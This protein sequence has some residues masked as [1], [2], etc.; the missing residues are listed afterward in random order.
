MAYTMTAAL[1]ASPFLVSIVGHYHLQVRN[2]AP[3]AWVYTP[4][5]FSRA[6]TFWRAFFAP[7]VAG[8]ISLIGWAR[9]FSMSGAGSGA[10]R[11]LTTSAVVC[12]L[13]LA[14]SYLVQAARAYG[15]W[16]PSIVPG[17][18][19]LLLFGAFQAVGFGVGLAAIVNLGWQLAEN[20]WVELS[21]RRT[22]QA[23][24]IVGLAVIVAASR[25]PAY[26][27][28]PDFV[29]ERQ[30]AQRM[31]ADPALREMLQW[32]RRTPST[33]DVVLAGD[34]LGLSVVGAAGRK[35]VAVDRLFS[36]PFVDW[37]E[38][39]RDRDEMQGLLA[40]WADGDEPRFLSLAA[41]Y[42]VRYVAT[43]TDLAAPGFVAPTRPLV[44]RS[45]V[46]SIYQVGP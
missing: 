44:W 8:L 26:V 10:V 42:R 24:L 43:P 2:P 41:K 20:W 40:R 14:S 46:W 34:S 25:Y 19:F 1:V 38:R 5:E 35:V 33:S 11:C 32:L 15:Y 37:S 17:F 12:G 27:M 39:A 16:L 9:L 28:R 3:S 23:L 30:S 45:G 31:F 36:N 21:G 13:W 29:E 7:S 22:I 18:H 6:G 4:L